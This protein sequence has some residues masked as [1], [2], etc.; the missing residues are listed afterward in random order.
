MDDYQGLALV[1]FDLI[2]ME[3]L[4]LFGK[5]GGNK[6]RGASI[7]KASSGGVASYRLERFTIQAPGFTV[8]ND[9]RE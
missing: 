3:Q 7:T 2:R 1:P 8:G 6:G 4:E 9:C 5:P